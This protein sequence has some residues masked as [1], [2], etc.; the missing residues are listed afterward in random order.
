MQR[1][2]ASSGSWIPSLWASPPSR[3]KEALIL[4]PYTS[5]PNQQCLTVSPVRVEGG[6]PHNI[7]FTHP[8]RVR[9][10]L[11]W[12][13]WIIDLP[14][15]SVEELLGC[16]LLGSGETGLYSWSSHCSAV[17][18]CKSHL[19]PLVFSFLICKA[20]LM[21]SPSLLNVRIRWNNTCK[22]PAQCLAYSQP[23]IQV[24]YIITALPIFKKG[25]TERTCV[26]LFIQYDKVEKKLTRESEHNGRK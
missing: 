18:P 14:G 20:V 22:V 6:K 1:K 19:T 17:W 24:T 25:K 16:Q 12:P 3:C 11:L 5:T 2:D 13:N 4:R 21:A 26:S 8:M 23:S 9:A 10:V 7:L 15:V